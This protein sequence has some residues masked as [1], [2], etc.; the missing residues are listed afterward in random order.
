LNETYPPQIETGPVDELLSDIVNIY[1][2]KMS[3]QA[4][5]ELTSNK[6]SKAAL[7][8]LVAIRFGLTQFK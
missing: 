6:N 5:K 7:D 3:T 4:L 2:L 1:L 8:A